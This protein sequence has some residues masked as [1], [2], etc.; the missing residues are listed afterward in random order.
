MGTPS[1]TRCALAAIQWTSG[2]HMRITAITANAFAEDRAECL[3]AGM[4]D[5]LAKPI[6]LA[7]LKAALERGLE[8]GPL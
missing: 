7:S 8:I 6:R 1:S 3:A 2:E 5:Y 4:D